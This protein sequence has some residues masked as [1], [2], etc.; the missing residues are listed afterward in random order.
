M[1]ERMAV[2]AALLLVVGT[3]SGVAARPARPAAVRSWSHAGDAP[4][5]PSQAR[6]R[7]AGTPV[8]VQSGW[9]TVTAA[10]IPVGWAR[11]TVEVGATDGTAGPRTL[12][13]ILTAELYIEFGLAIDGSETSVSLA[14]NQPSPVSRAVGNA[15]TVFHVG[16]DPP[17]EARAVAL[18]LAEPWEHLVDLGGGAWGLSNDRLPG[19]TV[20]RIVRQTEHG[21]A[22]AA[23]NRLPT[24]VGEPADWGAAEAAL[25]ELAGSLD[26]HLGPDPAALDTSSNAAGLR[27]LTAAWKASR[28][29][30]TF[31]ITRTRG[32]NS[33]RKT[34]LFHDQSRRL[35][36]AGYSR[37][38]RR[39]LRL[40]PHAGLRALPH[41][42]RLPQRRP[43]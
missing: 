26:G 35:H 40:A 16:F 3:S 24:L 12:D 39:P 23:A 20:A 17:L 7:A 25:R 31:T 21:V 22:V 14:H 18:E 33:A 15:A 43:L 30:T 34:M 27:A 13:T 5:H 4:V 32:T 2:G 1:R 19:A 8:V 9:E 28:G 10:A 38:L 6:A 42:R 29:A 36:G 37:N 11:G 41:S